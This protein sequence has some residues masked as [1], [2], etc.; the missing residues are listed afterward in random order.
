MP[1]STG[2]GEVQFDHEA[3]KAF[4]DKLVTTL[5]NDLSH[6]RLALN[7]APREVEAGSFTTFCAALAHA[8][9]QGVEYADVDLVTKLRRL[10]EAGDGIATTAAVMA[11]AAE[12]STVKKQ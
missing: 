10:K 12:A 2:T 8:Y 9:T 5:G 6:A 1:I 3:L 4:G 7:A 11:A